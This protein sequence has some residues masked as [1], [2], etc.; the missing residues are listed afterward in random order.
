MSGSHLADLL[1][2]QQIPFDHGEKVGNAQPCPS[3]QAGK[4]GRSDR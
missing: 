2:D 3:S 1:L 4:L